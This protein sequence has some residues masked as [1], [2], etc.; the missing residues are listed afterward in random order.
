[1]AAA[2]VKG[3][4]T[5][6]EKYPDYYTDEEA[7][8][9]DEVTVMPKAVNG[10]TFINDYTFTA[11]TKN[12]RDSGSGVQKVTYAVWSEAHPNVQKWQSVF[13]PTSGK[14]YSLTLDIRDFGEDTGIYHIY[15]YILDNAGNQIIEQTTANV[16]LD[17]TLPECAGVSAAPDPA[18]MTF[19]VTASGI[20]DAESGVENVA[21]EVWAESGGQDDV[22]WYSS[23]KESDGVYSC[24]VNAANHLNQT[25]KYCINVYARDYAGT[26]GIVASTAVT[27]TKD[28]TAPQ[29]D[30]VEITPNPVAGYT[31]TA[32][33]KN[34]RDSGSGVQK[35]TYAVWSE[36][37]PNVQKWQSVFAPTS[38]KDYSLT[39]DIRDFGEDTGIYHIYAYILDNAG[40]QIIEQ[41]TANVQLDRTL[42]ECAGVS[43]AP[44]PAEMTFKVTASG[45][46]DAES[47]VENVAF[48]VWAESGGQDD[49]KWYS[50]TKESDGVYS[51]EVN[52]AN[53]LNQTGKYCIN[54][55]ARDYAGNVGVVASTAVTVTGNTDKPAISAVRVEPENIT[56]LSFV[57]TASGVTASAGIDRVSFAVWTDANGQDDIYW[58]TGISKGNGTYYANIDLRRHNSETGK[59]NIH[60]YAYD[61]RNNAVL[62]ATTATVSSISSTSIMGSPQVTVAQMINFFNNKGGVYPDYYTNLGVP[63]QKFAQYYYDVCVAEGVRPEVAWV[64]MLCETGYLRFGGDVKMEQF[65]FAGIGATGGGNSGYD[66]AAVYGADSVGLAAGVKAHIQHLKAYAS[67]ANVVY[68]NSSGAPFD[69]R[70]SLVTRGSAP[71]VEGLGCRWASNALYPYTL[72]SMLNQLSSTPAAALNA[73]SLMMLP[74]QPAEQPTGLQETEQPTEDKQTAAG[75]EPAGEP[76]ADPEPE[77]SDVPQ[78]ETEPPAMPEPQPQNENTAA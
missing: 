34:V 35:V 75:S 76:S 12:V 49:V 30:G 21:F 64:Q 32:T 58:Y 38:G 29:H 24:E 20:T 62:K 17:R 11:T 1:M 41:T 70:F 44:D 46:T 69:P 18:E 53:H 50:S 60:V 9:F 39:L 74:T 14:D 42:P 6:Q 28:V 67:T 51:C 10:Y 4:Q 5:Y 15:A 31:F 26:V 7:P 27:V 45:I 57:A 65:N 56:A 78:A 40:N 63:L 72:L 23:T 59:Y 71:T 3:I 54:V 61:I 13:A 68:T 25:G 16:Q 47:G 55:Y 73:A 43:A 66:F 77:L 8:T 48:E 52:A 33:T 19:K 2:I 22:K 37:H 36:A